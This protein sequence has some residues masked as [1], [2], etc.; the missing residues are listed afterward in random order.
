MTLHA[1]VATHSYTMSPPCSAVR[2]GYRHNNN[3]THLVLEAH[4]TDV[5][6]EAM[7]LTSR[8]DLHVTA[9][10]PRRAEAHGFWMLCWVWSGKN[11]ASKEWMRCRVIVG[12]VILALWDMRGTCHVQCQPWTLQKYM[13]RCQADRRGVAFWQG[14]LT[15]PA[16]Y[17]RH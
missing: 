1:C 8:E 16:V 5:C 15:D 6:R 13:T 10:G 14:Y 11:L 4:S 2:S 9:A 12:P 7:V 17:R 3:N